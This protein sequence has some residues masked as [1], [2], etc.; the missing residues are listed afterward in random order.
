[1]STNSSID[2]KDSIIAHGDGDH[3]IFYGI[4]SP[5]S[6]SKNWLSSSVISGIESNLKLTMASK[7]LSSLLRKHSLCSQLNAPLSEE[8]VLN[9]YN[10]HQIEKLTCDITT[11]ISIFDKRFSLK[12][13]DIAEKVTL[14]DNSFFYFDNFW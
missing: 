4:L 2:G 3:K 5:V 12:F 10:N 7:Y 6:A 8:K 13:A 1:L 9:E 14:V 11:V